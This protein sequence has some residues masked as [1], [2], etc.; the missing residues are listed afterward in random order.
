MWAKLTRFLLFC[1]KLAPE[2]P[3]NSRVEL[4]ILAISMICYHVASE[5]DAAFGKVAA[6]HIGNLFA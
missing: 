5:D 1:N 6:D 3:G 4:S 2:S